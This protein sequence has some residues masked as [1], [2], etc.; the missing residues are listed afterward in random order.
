[1][2]PKITHS[3]VLPTLFNA[4][5]VEVILK[6]Q[7]GEKA[8]LD[9]TFVDITKKHNALKAEFQNAVCIYGEDFKLAKD[10]PI[11]KAYIEMHGSISAAKERH[12]ILDMEIESQAAILRDSIKPEGVQIA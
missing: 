5:A 10:S 2:E 11:G 1:M 9:P 12:K 8:K 7:L 3:Q 6:R 4:L